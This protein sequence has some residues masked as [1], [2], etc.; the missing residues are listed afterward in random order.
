MVE[1]RKE[2]SVKSLFFELN[3]QETQPQIEIVNIDMWK[4]YINVMRD[5]SPHALQVHDKFHLIKKL[6]EC[7]DK[8]RKE[9]VETQE[10]LKN[11]KYTVLNM[12]KIEQ[13][14]NKGTLR[15]FKL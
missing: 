10:L 7:I 13:S 3:E 1:G 15:Q 9:E 2:K 6:S 12:L 8:T 5:I 14:N 11:Q 4:A